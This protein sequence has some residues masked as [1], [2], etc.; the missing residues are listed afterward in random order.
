MLCVERVKAPLGWGWPVQGKPVLGCSISSVSCKDTAKA[1]LSLA[2]RCWSCTSPHSTHQGNPIP[3][4]PFPPGP[5][6]RR[7]GHSSDL[8]P[9]S[10]PSCQRKVTRNDSSRGTYCKDSWFC[11]HP[12]KS[13]KI[14]SA[15]GYRI[16]KFWQTLS[17]FC[18]GREVGTM[19]QWSNSQDKEQ[20]VSILWHYYQVSWHAWLSICGSAS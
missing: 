2:Q 17:H 16:L 7:G 19:K 13:W 5:Q 1:A 11:G 9:L 14:Y 10:F 4:L 12:N 20:R 18:S 8:Q 15:L 6:E 3:A